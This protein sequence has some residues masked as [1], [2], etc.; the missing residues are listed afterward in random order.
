M[1]AASNPSLTSAQRAPLNPAAEV[2]SARASADL[3]GPQLSE[4]GKRIEMLRVDRGVP[5]QVLAKAAGTSRQQLWRVM[6][7]KSELTSTL[8]QRLASVLDVD[9]RTLSSAVFAGDG[10]QHYPLTLN[11]TRL[12]A[13]VVAPRSLA[14]YLESSTPL[15]RT[16]RTLPPGEDGVALKC[17]VLNALEDRARA[18]RLQIPAWLFRVRASVLDGTL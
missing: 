15:V 6:T 7:G 14:H 1:D 11:P 2:S 16:L 3:T 12:S 5:K 13:A 10:H 18:A 17:A 8:C 4:L 9:S